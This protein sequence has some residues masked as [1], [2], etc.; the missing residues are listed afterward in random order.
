MFDWS[1]TCIGT[2]LNTLHAARRS[3]IEAESSEKIRRALRFDV[4]TYVDEE[5]VTGDTVYYRR[6]NWKGS[7]S[8]AKVLGQ[9]GQCVLI[10][11]V[12]TFYRMHPSHLMKA[13][14]E[15][16]SLRKEGNKEWGSLNQTAKNEINEIL[17]EED[18]QHNK[19]LHINRGIERQK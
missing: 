7:H 14:K 16:G 9:E 8:P 19:S 13:N 2:N 4:R 18:E 5:F 10:R 12:G 1:I 6:Q 15:F 3:F 17:E 11:H